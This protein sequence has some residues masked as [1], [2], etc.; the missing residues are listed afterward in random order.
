MAGDALTL[1]EDLNRC[2]GDAGLD[3]LA[4]QLRGHR[5][6]VV[7]DLD[8]VVGSDAGPLPFGVLVGLGR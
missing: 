2:V 7:R 5:V 6:E 3:D 1:V 8:V 4:D